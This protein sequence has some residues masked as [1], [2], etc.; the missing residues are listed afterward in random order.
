MTDTPQESPA[1]PST[2][3]TVVLEIERHVA[4]SGWDGP[5]QVYALVDTLELVATE[6]Q[7]A[8]RLGIAPLEVAAGSLTPVEQEALA[9]EP[10]EDVLATIAWPDD[11]LGCA[12]VQEVIVLPPEAE[13]A[14]PEDVDPVDWAADHPDRQ[15]ARMAVGV[16]RD[17]SRAAALRLR[18]QNGDSDDDPGGGDVLVGDDLVPNLAEALLA[19]LD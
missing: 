19:T 17:G 11:V 13:A 8:S 5:P 1:P 15:E 16:L 18:G 3:Q 12:L 14:R 9:D 6:P 10:L 4:E 7:L 2:L